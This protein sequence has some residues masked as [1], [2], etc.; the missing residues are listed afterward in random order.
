[1][2]LRRSK[3]VLG[4]LPIPPQRLRRV[5]LDATAGLIEFTEVVL[6]SDIA[7]FRRGPVQVCRLGERCRRALTG[8]K[9][10]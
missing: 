8:E 4:A 10:R 7:C 2:P 1:M 6:R 9:P 3:T 5:A